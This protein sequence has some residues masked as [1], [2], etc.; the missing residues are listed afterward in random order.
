MY[1]CATSDELR[2]Y[3]IVTDNLTPFAGPQCFPQVFDDN[4]YVAPSPGKVEAAT[5]AR[6]QGHLEEQLSSCWLRCQNPMCKKLRL[7][8]KSSLASLTSEAFMEGTVLTDDWKEWLGRAGSRYT[9]AVQRQDELAGVAGVGGTEGAVAGNHVADK[10]ED[11]E[12]VREDVAD[13]YSGA[14]SDSDASGGEDSE[15]SRGDSSDESF[16]D[17]RGVSEGGVC[18]NTAEWADV[19]SGLGSWGEVGEKE[20]GRGRDEHPRAA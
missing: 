17:D 15:G 1:G 20:R 7:V 8:E 4:R 6:E 2:K 10:E 3:P 5:A 9:A 16:I 14:S 19:M 11:A 12:G 18:V 13:V